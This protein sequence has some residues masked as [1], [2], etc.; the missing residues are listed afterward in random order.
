MDILYAAL[1]MLALLC[2][3]MAVR[4]ARLLHAALWLA[5]ASAALA[6]LL[7]AAGAH[8][9]AVIE[10]SVGAGLVTVLFVFAIAIAGDEAL[11]APPVVPRPLAW[12]ATG[13]LL[14][15]I[16]AAAWQLP[17][18]GAA[19]SGRFADTFWQ[20]RVLDV[21]AQVV[22][23]FAGALGVLGLLAEPRAQSGETPP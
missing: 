4:A 6:G 7:Y 9:V 23:L 11:N 20:A 22:L 15:I 12:A 5:G 16:G 3:G 13:L 2:A 8:E 14:A 19:G 21:A 18:D 1:G 10:L 17:P